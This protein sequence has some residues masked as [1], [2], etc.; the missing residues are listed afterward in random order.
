MRYVDIAKRFPK[1]S[2]EARK[3]VGK[4]I[5]YRRMRDMYYEERTTLG[6][7]EK[8]MYKNI[9]INGEWFWIPDFFDYC[10]E[11]EYERTNNG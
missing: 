2:K 7:V 10:L 1:T 4:L 9:M 8:V 5:R 6:R 3:L 11:T